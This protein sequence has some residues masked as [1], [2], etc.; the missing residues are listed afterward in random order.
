MTDSEGLKTDLV[1]TIYS[2]PLSKTGFDLSDYVKGGGGVKVFPYA[3]NALYEILQ[4]LGCKTGDVALVPAFICRDVLSPFNELGLVVRY[5][6]VNEKLS[7]IRF[8]CHEK[9][10]KVVLGIHYFGLENDFNFLK[11]VCKQKKACF[12]VDNAHGFLSR[13]SYGSYLGTEA[14]WGIV[15][16]RKSLPIPSG[17]LLFSRHSKGVDFSLI[18]DLSIPLNLRLKSFL[19]NFVD[20]V[21]LRILNLVVNFKRLLRRVIKGEEVPVS[22]MEDEFRLPN[23][24]KCYDLRKYLLRINV[25]KE[26]LRRRQLFELLI[27][28]LKDQPVQFFR[29]TLGANEVPY[30]FPFICNSEEV[31]NVK[32]FLGQYD[33]EVVKWPALPDSVVLSESN[34]F[35]NQVY[36]VKFLW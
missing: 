9:K 6:E 17:A 13:N 10:V 21:P 33:L 2:P 3:R 20:F 16:I 14:D 12:I 5:Y 11:E 19:S 15:S 1:K 31:D 32:A 7:P 34:I 35:Y 4:R 25:E 24:K 27:N 23:S 22:T 8:V 36:F 30:A 29:N 26:V 18:N 28:L